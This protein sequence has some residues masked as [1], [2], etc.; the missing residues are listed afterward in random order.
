MLTLFVNNPDNLIKI[1]VQFD[2]AQLAAAK[3]AA[4]HLV[5]NVSAYITVVDWPSKN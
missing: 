5:V 1:T 2:S 4:D 3:L